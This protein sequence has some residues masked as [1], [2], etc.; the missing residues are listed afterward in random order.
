MRELLYNK[1]VRRSDSVH[2]MKNRETP[3]LIQD[4]CPQLISNFYTAV[5]PQFENGQRNKENF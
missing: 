1:R 2:N 5:A 4:Y 3:D